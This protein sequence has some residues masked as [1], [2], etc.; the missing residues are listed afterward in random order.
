MIFV[1]LARVGLRVL[2]SNEEIGGAFTW[3]KF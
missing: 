2:V 1:Y 3:N